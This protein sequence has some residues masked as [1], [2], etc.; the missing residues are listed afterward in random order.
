MGGLFDKFN[1]MSKLPTNQYGLSASPQITR[2]SLIS[3]SYPKSMAMIPNV[4]HDS[5]PMIIVTDIW[6]KYIRGVN[7]HYL[8]FPHVRSLLT[9]YGGNTGFSY[10]A[11]RNSISE[12]GTAWCDAFRIYIRAGVGRPKKLD[13]EWLKSILTEVRSFDP[14]EIEKIRSTIQK[15]IQSRL[16]VKAKELTSYEQWRKQLTESQKSQLRG[17]VSDIH[18]AITR[19]ATENLINASPQNFGQDNT[20][21]PDINQNN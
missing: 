17:K 4:I 14:G 11:V 1:P 3:F 19:G 10:D 8:M 16:Q 15:Q 7:L 2:G 20:M 21:T 9:K 6:P 13:S 5:Q 12:V 18:N